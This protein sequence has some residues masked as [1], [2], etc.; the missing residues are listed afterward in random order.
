[1]ALSPAGSWT[2]DDKFGIEAI[3]DLKMPDPDNPKIEEVCYSTEFHMI[4]LELTSVFVSSG[5]H[6]V[7][8]V[9]CHGQHVHFHVS[10]VYLEGLAWLQ[11]K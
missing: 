8:E 1:M 3:F 9:P 6:A 5:A 11:R 4:L 10:M 2:A 7:V